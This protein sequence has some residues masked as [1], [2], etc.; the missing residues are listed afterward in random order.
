M[1][2]ER[3]G[4]GGWE[5]RINRINRIYRI[6]GGGGGG[7]DRINRINRIYGRVEWMGGF[8]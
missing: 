1:R 6:G 3:V 8:H 5:D 4:K 7:G 2:V